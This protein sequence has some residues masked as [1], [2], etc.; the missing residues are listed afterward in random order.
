MAPGEITSVVKIDFVPPRFPY[1]SV[2]ADLSRY[3]EV[4]RITLVRT[5]IVRHHH[6]VV[7]LGHEWLK[8]EPKSE[9]SDTTL[10][11]ESKPGDSEDVSVESETQVTPCNDV[12]RADSLASDGWVV[13]LESHSQTKTCTCNQKK[14]V[15]KR[16]KF[17]KALPC[18][19]CLMRIFTVFDSK[20]AAKECGLSLSTF[21]KLL[22]EKHIPVYPSRI[23]KSI[24]NC[25]HQLEKQDKPRT[26]SVSNDLSV[27]R[28]ELQRQKERLEAACRSTKDNPIM[29]EGVCKLS[30]TFCKIR[31]KLYKRT[32]RMNLSRRSGFGSK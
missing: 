21:K 31:H 14:L 16:G 12:Q 2:E 9:S 26:L 19:R 18:A 24:T 28:L 20:K 32:H 7:R 5:R 3:K 13:P 23:L 29:V 8:K 11:R 1:S 22:R 6:H 15:V 10:S 4:S 27:C 30:G 25:I 17:T